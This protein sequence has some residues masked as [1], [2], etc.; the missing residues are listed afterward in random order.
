MVVWVISLIIYSH[1]T[2]YLFLR[3]PQF[4]N[5]QPQTFFEFFVSLFFQLYISYPYF[6]SFVRILCDSVLIS[7]GIW[8]QV[9]Y[10][11][12]NQRS[13]SITCCFEDL[14]CIIHTVNI[15][16][17]PCD[18]LFCIRHYGIYFIF[19]LCYFSLTFIL[20]CHILLITLKSFFQKVWLISFHV[21]NNTNSFINISPNHL[22][23]VS[24]YLQSLWICLK[25]LLLH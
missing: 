3:I 7:A 23:V 10:I 6:L 12:L 8:V 5:L 17:L 2:I 1:K 11:Y 16:N 14:P 21:N 22:T 18:T 4:F 15:L 24:K 13:W 19:N 9:Q 20:R 25:R